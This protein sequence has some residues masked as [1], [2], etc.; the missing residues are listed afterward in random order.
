ML[1]TNPVGNGSSAVVTRAALDAVS[2]ERGGR[3]QWF[4]ESLRRSEDIDMWCRL[5]AAGVSARG[6]P[7][8]LVRYRVSPGGL[9]SDGERQVESWIAVRDRLALIAPDAVRRVG[10]LA[11]ASQMRWQARKAVFAGDGRSAASWCR[12]MVAAHPA[13]LLH[14]PAKTWATVA[15]AAACVAAPSLTS[16]LVR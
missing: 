6:I 11:L 8:P 4:D 2:F 1:L 9:S 3:T 10:G 15:A 7:D 12:R 16:R 5:L 13:I 14:E